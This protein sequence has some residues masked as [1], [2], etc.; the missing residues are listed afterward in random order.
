[1]K[2]GKIEIFYDEDG[3][4]EIRN[5]PDSGSSVGPIIAIIGILLFLALMNDLCGLTL[6]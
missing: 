5:K 1:M 4:K 2:K 6:F 3:F